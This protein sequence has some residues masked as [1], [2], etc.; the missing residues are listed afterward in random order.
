VGTTIA[1]LP[2]LKRLFTLPDII[3]SFLSRTRT[4]TRSSNQAIRQTPEK[5]GAVQV[6]G[7]N[8]R[9]GVEDPEQ[10]SA[11]SDSNRTRT[12]DITVAPEPDHEVPQGGTF[13]VS[14]SAHA[15]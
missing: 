15:H 2:A 9:N 5:E 12:T 7:S 8:S 10:A 14:Q 1:S 13:H 6:I 4:R 11:S 3:K